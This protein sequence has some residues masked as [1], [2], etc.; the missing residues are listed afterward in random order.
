MKA[1]LDIYEVSIPSSDDVP[2]LLG[3]LEVAP[4][5]SINLPFQICQCFLEEN[6]N[7]QGSY[8]K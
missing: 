3:V 2:V 1:L 6:K 8:Y 4:L 5:K 7:K